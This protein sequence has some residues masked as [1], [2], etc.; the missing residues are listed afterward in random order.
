MNMGMNM[1]NNA[2]EKTKAQIT[3]PKTSID[4]NDFNWPPLIRV[5]HFTLAELK[6]PHWKIVRN[7][8]FYLLFNF[9]HFILNSISIITQV[10][11]GY[12][13]LRILS[14]ILVF[15]ILISLA[16]FTFYNAYRGICETPALLLRYKI[17]LGVLFTIHFIM[18][19][20]NTLNFN[21]IVR[22]VRIFKDGHGFAGFLC[23]LEIFF[24]I[25]IDVFAGLLLFQVLNWK[26]PVVNY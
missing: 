2:F 23:L 10:I 17:G 18:L 12:S 25:G 14:C 24:I 26:H 4:W 11:V 3:A 13:G 9:A 5:V 6:E 8:Y 20:A 16:T 21:G 7:L 15:I 19:I 1:A 22:A